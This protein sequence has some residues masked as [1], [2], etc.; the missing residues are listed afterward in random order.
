MSELRTN[1]IIPRDGL[2]S[3]T[4]NGGGIIQV[5]QTVKTD[6]YSESLNAHTTASADAMQVAITPVSYTHLRAHET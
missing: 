2:V 3:G 1:R 4:F 5:K 6:V